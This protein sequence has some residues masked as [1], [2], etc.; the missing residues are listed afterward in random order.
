MLITNIPNNI[1]IFRET[2]HPVTGLTVSHGNFI[3]V[4]YAS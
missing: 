1:A 4:L 2:E 3:P